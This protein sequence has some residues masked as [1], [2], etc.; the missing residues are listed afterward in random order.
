[1]A[2]I[3]TLGASSRPTTNYFFYRVLEP[4]A[5]EVDRLFNASLSV[6]TLK[7]YKRAVLK[8][9]AFREQYNRVPKVREKSVKKEKNSRSGKSQGILS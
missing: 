4:F 8:F 5:N 7:L 6:D 2:G 3:Q 9:D 1:M